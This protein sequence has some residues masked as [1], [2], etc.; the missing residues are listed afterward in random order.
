MIIKKTTQKAGAPPLSPWVLIQK[1]E[2]L[3]FIH[4]PVSPV[5]LTSQIPEGLELDTYDGQAWISIVALK[6]SKNRIRYLPS[7]PYQHPMLQLNV[8]TYVKRKG[9]KGVYFFTMDT[10][11]LSVVFG[12]KIVKAPFL[13]AAMKMK[14]SADTYHLD[15]LRKGNLPAVFHASYTPVG[16]AFYPERQSLDYWLLERYVFWTYKKNHLYRGAIQHERWKVRNA[17]VNIDKLAFSSFL[18]KAVIG[19]NPVIHYARSKIARNGII[20]KMK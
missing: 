6:V 4:L 20:K 14:Q 15:S 1:W 9:E 2:H 10:N 18:S 11:K 5:A 17:K 16:E 12:G 7:I 19:E 3:L 13:H 8:R